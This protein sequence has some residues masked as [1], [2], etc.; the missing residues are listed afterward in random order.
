MI[1]QS[2]EEYVED[3]GIGDVELPEEEPVKAFF[4]EV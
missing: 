4:V 2:I 1:R 3:K